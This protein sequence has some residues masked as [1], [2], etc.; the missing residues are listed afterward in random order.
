MHNSI[1]IVLI[2]LGAIVMFLSIL[3][4]RRV[5]KLV[6][7]N[8]YYKAWKILLSL[9]IFFLFGYAAV[10]VLLLLKIQFF[11]LLLTGTIFFFGAL[12][13]YL[14]VKTE[15]LTLQD[16]LTT[17]LHQLD[18]RKSKETAEAIA[19]SKSEFLAVMSHEIRTPMNAVLGMTE[20]LLDTPL[21]QQQQEFTQTIHTSG[22]ALLALIDDILD[23]SKLEADKLEL[24]QQ[25]FEL[26]V[27]IEEALE[28][29]AQKIGTKPLDLIYSIDSEVPESIESDLTRLRQVLLNLVSNA[30]KF[31]EAG[32]V[33]VQV[34]KASETELFFSI[35]DTGIG[36][37]LEKQNKLFQP[38]SQLDSSTNRK[39]GGTGLGLAI[40]Q[41]LI[42]AMGGNIGCES[43]PEGGTTFFFTI[44]LKAAKIPN[45]AQTISS[46]STLQGKRVLILDH[47]QIVCQ[48]LSD[49]C[50]RWQMIPHV[51]NSISTALEEPNQKFGFDLAIIDVLL[52][53]ID[54]EDSIAKL[55]QKT[56]NPKLPIVLLGS[57]EQ[58]KA[59]NPQLSSTILALFKPIKQSQLAQTILQGIEGKKA[60]VANKD[61]AQRESQLAVRFPAKILVA[62]DNQVNQKIANH[63]FRKL[64]YQINLVSNGLA[65]LEAVQ[66][67]HYDLIFM[68]V[69]MPVMD[70]LEATRQL[71][72]HG[73]PDCHPIIIAMTANALQEDYTACLQ[74]GMDDYISKPVKL[75]KLQAAIAKWIA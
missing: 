7:N 11:I 28:I 64:G 41:K 39:Y 68:D 10:V 43:G 31:T 15:F 12:F 23:F 51:C 50:K 71:R 70:G 49:Y 58:L 44:P 62:E 61:D 35:T 74:A 18:L 19:R 67:C 65:V 36:I 66:Q 52:P 59:L 55:R 17:R 53:G 40:C 1:T 63:M 2:I 25:A 22:G 46:L 60:L 26:R 24:E 42:Q 33:L 75:Q 14:V 27:C 45:K 30:V 6:R 29:S 37:P 48:T 54:K 3:E 13:V 47:N 21:N 4:T 56:A 38:F 20:L 9:M 72:Q 57:F 69:Q 8:Q 34:K 16:L 73:A 32:E 5:L